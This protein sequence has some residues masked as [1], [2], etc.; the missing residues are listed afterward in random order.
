MTTTGIMLRANL[1]WFGREQSKFHAFD[2]G[3]FIF[4]PSAARVLD[5]LIPM[6]WVFAA[7]Q[8]FCGR[9]RS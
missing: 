4:M 5:Q 6:L 8:V 7:S 2:D 3:V 9:C 1:T